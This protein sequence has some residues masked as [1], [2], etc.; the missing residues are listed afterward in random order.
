MREP[1][2]AR[3]PASAMLAHP[4]HLLAPA[5]TLASPETGLEYRIERLLGEG[6]F[7]QVYH[8]AQ[9]GAVLAP[10]GGPAD[11]TGYR[12]RAT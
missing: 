4:R 6:G 1:A 3:G 8:A 2:H 5:Q 9:R 7:G 12:L 10:R 11:V